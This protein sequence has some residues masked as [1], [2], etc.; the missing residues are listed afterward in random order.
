MQSKTRAHKAPL[1]SAYVDYTTTDEKMTQENTLATRGRDM[2]RVNLFKEADM[3]KMFFLLGMAV[4]LAACQPAAT[5]CPPA[6]VA[7][8]APAPADTET[9]TDS[10]SL[11]IGTWFMNNTGYLDIRGTGSATDLTYTIYNIAPDPWSPVDKGTM[12]FENGKLTYLTSQ[13]CKDTAQATYDVYLVKH[14]GRVIG[15]RTK[16]VGEDTCVN[17]NVFINNQLLEY[18]GPLF[19]IGR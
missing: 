9:L 14:E 6:A 10:I 15:M 8:A 2:L 7:P 19:F 12:R 18:I 13:D 4:L 3:K 1:S 17:R 5:P 16:V 11:V